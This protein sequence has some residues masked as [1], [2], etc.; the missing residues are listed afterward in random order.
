MKSR[1][2]A[3]EMGDVS[4]MQRLLDDVVRIVDDAAQL[5]LRMLDDGVA[6]WR[7][8]DRSPVT[9]ID[10][11]VDRMLR[12][13]LRDTLPTAGW[14]SEETTDD[15]IRL[16]RELVWIVDPIDGTRSLMENTDEFAISVALSRAGDGP[17]LG[18]V[19]NP[20]RKERFVALKGQGAWQL[21]G[22]ELR[23]ATRHGDDGL[24]LLVSRTELRKG[25]WRNMP[26]PCELQPTS[27]LAYKMALVARGD[28]DATLTP[29]PRSEWDAAAGQLLVSEA[30]GRTTD[31]FGEPLIF[32][33]A[34]P[35][36]RGIVVASRAAWDDVL[37]LAPELRRRRDI[38]LDM[39]QRGELT[40]TGELPAVPTRA[41]RDDL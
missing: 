41:D 27:S 6:N 19:H 5:A 13:R 31:A 39:L 4:D 8:S 9:E 20:R 12:K 26:M 7:K 17:I 22:S 35:Q 28:A 33:S 10:I 16:D 30:G 40:E 32:N 11:A 21:E 29:W 25:L 38:V 14:L 1:A 18:V 37:A 36:L 15:V 2:A 34:S 23:C 3:A 24:R